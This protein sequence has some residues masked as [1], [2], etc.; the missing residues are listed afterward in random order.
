MKTSLKKLSLIFFISLLLL[1]YPLR[2]QAEEE[3]FAQAKNIQI[4]T[5]YDK[6]TINVSIE[7]IR[8]RLFKGEPVYFV[9]K[10]EEGK[11][12]IKAEW[13]ANALK[14]EYSVEKID[15]QNAIIIGDLDFHIKD[16]LIN[17]DESG[18]EE[19]EI[20]ELKNRGIEKV[21]LISSFI[22]IGNC[23]L[24]GDLKAGYDENH[25]SIIVF[26]KFVV[27]SDSTVKEAFFGSASF[28]EKADFSYASFNNKF[29]LN[30]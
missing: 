3:V 24:Q 29:V 18:M 19:D 15:I 27:F 5:N 9:E 22:N 17:I 25:E 12:T 7:D 21:F 13:I 14:K 20:K 26:E 1:L 23:Q 16:N 6:E 10:Q 11:R 4:L 8:E 30:F 2:S 28:K